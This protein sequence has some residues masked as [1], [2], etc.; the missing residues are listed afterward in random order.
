MSQINKTKQVVL[1]PLPVPAFSLFGDVLK[2]IAS[3]FFYS[4]QGKIKYEIP[5]GEVLLGPIREEPSSCLC[6]SY[7]EVPKSRLCLYLSEE[8]TWIIVAVSC[9]CV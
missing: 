4:S 6:I 5:E 9:P 8:Y 1:V 3:Y 2:G 7:F